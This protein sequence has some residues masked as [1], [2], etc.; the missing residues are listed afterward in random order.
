MNRL[1]QNSKG[2]AY[3]I[4]CAIMVVIIAFLFTF[5][6]Y[7][8]LTGAFKTKQDILATVPVWWHSEFVSTTLKTS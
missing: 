1:D 3:F 7:W 2:K 8:I 4:F 5:P 6:L